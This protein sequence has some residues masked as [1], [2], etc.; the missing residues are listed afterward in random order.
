MSV[1]SATSCAIA[2]VQKSLEF[3]ITSFLGAA[4]ARIIHP[5]NGRFDSDLLAKARAWREVEGRRKKP[6]QLILHFGFFTLVRALLGLLP[7]DKAFAAASR[8]RL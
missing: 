1:V 3:G 2:S 7:L 4:D 5:S 6:W 8:P